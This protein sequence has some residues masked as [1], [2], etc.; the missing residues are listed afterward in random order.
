MFLIQCDCRCFFTLK[1]F[2]TENR[3][4]P[5]CPNCLKAIHI[6][7]EQSISEVA[8]ELTNAKISIREIPNDAKITVAYDL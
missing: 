1:E 7:R 2:P 5:V 4:W 3:Q 6:R 8:K